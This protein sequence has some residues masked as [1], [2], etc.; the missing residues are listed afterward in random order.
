VVALLATA[1]A[2]QVFTG[3]LVTTSTPTHHWANARTEDSHDYIIDALGYDNDTGLILVAYQTPGDL[4]NGDR[5]SL[6]E[7]YRDNGSVQN[8]Y[9]AYPSNLSYTGIGRPTCIAY[10]HKDMAFYV[11]TD[12]GYIVSIDP[13]YLTINSNLHVEE[14]SEDHLAIRHLYYDPA[15]N[16]YIIGAD[17]STSGNAY[18]I[19]TNGISGSSSVVSAT[20]VYP[21]NN[22]QITLTTLWTGIAGGKEV[23]YLRD[24]NGNLYLAGFDL[25]NYD[26]TVYN[27]T[28][29]YSL[30]PGDYTPGLYLDGDGMYVYAVAPLRD[31]HGYDDAV[32]AVFNLQG[33][34]TPP[35][36][37]VEAWNMSVPWRHADA[38]SITKAG[39][40]L[41]YIVGSTQVVNVTTYNISIL[42]LS[43]T[44]GLGQPPQ[45][46]HAWIIGGEYND[47]VLSNEWVEVSDYIY[48]GAL[49]RSFSD[50]Y[51]STLGEPGES[52]LTVMASPSLGNDTYAWQGSSLDESHPSQG[53]VAHSYT[54]P[55]LN[56]EGFSAYSSMSNLVVSDY[57]S[58]N[59]HLSDMQDVNPI[60]VTGGEVNSYRGLTADTSGSPTPV[61]EPALL[62]PVVAGASMVLAFYIARRIRG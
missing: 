11:G 41:F 55:P 17:G 26:S 25:S 53:V 37:P 16:K 27:L 56:V 48:I 22:N 29:Q 40:G 39:N 31:T 19:E 58:G 12:G 33:S 46:T 8:H 43:Y 21:S 47:K 30:A 51:N 35:L 10:V 59:I 60:D 32:L 61:P 6:M 36:S 18:I 14:D 23:T 42:E 28:L 5:F 24:Q 49:T 13:R 44:P 38:V 45:V 52:V 2:F 20:Y 1:L 3:I 7:I 62:I 4:A 54:S 50:Y 9:Y 57:P 34:T 15:S